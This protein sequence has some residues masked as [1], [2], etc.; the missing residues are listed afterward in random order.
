MFIKLV[1]VGADV[2]KPQNLTINNGFLN[3]FRV[4]EI[5]MQILMTINAFSIKV[6][7]NHTILKTN[8][9]I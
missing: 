4:L 7:E 3:M 6:C 5:A 8:T 2:T 9:K 1:L